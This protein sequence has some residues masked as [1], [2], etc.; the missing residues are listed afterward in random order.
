[1]RQVA[2]SIAAIVAGA[3]ALVAVAG[4]GVTAVAAS[5]GAPTVAVTITDTGVKLAA[6]TVPV[7]VVAFSVRNLGREAHVFR[8]GGKATPVLALGKRSMLRV[9]FARPGEYPYSASGV[10]TSSRQGNV[11]KVVRPATP[12]APSVPQ[13]PGATTTVQTAAQPCA[14]PGTTTVTVTMTDTMG[15]NSYTFSPSVIPCGTVTFLLQ[16]VGQSQHGLGISSPT[17]VQSP[18]G[19]IVDGSQSGTLTVKLAVTGT[20][21]WWD[22]AGEGFETTS[23]TLAVH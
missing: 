12:A 21:R 11:L 20:Y 9:D 2:V 14:S 8:I 19:P 22:A 16:N 1:M 23:G 17:G 7:G 4:V 10:R 6:R 5:A 3:G 13:G 15:P 18:A